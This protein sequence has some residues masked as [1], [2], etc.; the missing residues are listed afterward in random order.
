M[1]EVNPRLELFL[2]QIYKL[3]LFY[4]RAEDRKTGKILLR[5]ASIFQRL[6]E[7]KQSP[8]SKYSVHL[9]YRESA[10]ERHYA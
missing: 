10:R 9:A 1:G 8:I 3:N 2:K 6:F 4:L 5:F 7:T